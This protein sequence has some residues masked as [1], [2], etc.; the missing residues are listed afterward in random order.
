P[1]D[2]IHE[3]E[4]PK[5]WKAAIGDEP[6]QLGDRLAFAG[7]PPFDARRDEPE[8]T[9]AQPLAVIGV[10]RLWTAVG[11]HGDAVVED[12]VAAARED[13]RRL[14]AELGGDNGGVRHDR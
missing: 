4:K 1:L 7:D 13:A 9:A 5:H 10:E 11:K 2:Q 14:L 6:L 8:Q 3:L 12:R